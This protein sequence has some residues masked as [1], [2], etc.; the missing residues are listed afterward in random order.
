MIHFI[1]FINTAFI[2]KGSSNNEKI[3]PSFLL[4]TPITLF[5]VTA[6]I[7]EQTIDCIN[8]EAKG[9]VNEAVIGAIIAPR[10]SPS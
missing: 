9:A 1:I 5:L 10:N 6:F 3:L 8:E 4:P 2:A 7:N